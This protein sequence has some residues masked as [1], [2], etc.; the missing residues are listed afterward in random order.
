VLHC[1]ACVS[2]STTISSVFH[3]LLPSHRVSLYHQFTIILPVLHCLT[4]V[5][6][7]ITFSPCV[8]ISPVSHHLICASLSHLCFTIFYHLTVC[9]YLTK[10]N[11]ISPMHHCFVCVSLSTTIS[12]H[13]N[14]SLYH[15]F[16]ITVCS[17]H[18]QLKYNSRLIVFNLSH[19]I[20]W[21]LD[22]FKRFFLFICLLV[23]MYACCGMS[24]LF[25]IA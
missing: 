19:Y 2:I 10:F 25:K 18:Y 15:L 3:Y 9:H 1:L 5:S 12:L 24:W 20:S 8:T 17:L 21:P 13:D 4:C 7:S 16:T 6:L 11:I 22:N 23:S 14:V